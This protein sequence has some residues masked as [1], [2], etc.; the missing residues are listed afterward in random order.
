MSL[1]KR[2]FA[3]DGFVTRR[4]CPLLALS[5]RSPDRLVRSGSGRKADMPNQRV[6]CP[7]MTHSGLSGAEGW[8]TTFARDNDIKRAALVIQ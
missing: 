5:G 1:T 7:L 4:A 3:K 6:E 8:G 2:G